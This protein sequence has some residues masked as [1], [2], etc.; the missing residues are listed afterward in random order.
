[1]V[2]GRMPASV[3]ANYERS[4]RSTAGSDKPER[5]KNTP[6]SAAGARNARKK[7]K[8]ALLTPI[9]IGCRYYAANAKEGWEQ[10]LE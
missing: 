4:L 5:E 7:Q 1:M 2:Q 3:P 9:K 8:Q 10:P 6:N